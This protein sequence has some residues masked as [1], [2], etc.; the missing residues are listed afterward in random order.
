MKTDSNREYFMRHDLHMNTT[1]KEV[2]AQQIAATSIALFQGQKDNRN[3]KRNN[4]EN[5]TPMM[6]KIFGK[7][8]PKIRLT[9]TT[10]NETEKIINSI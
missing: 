2:C 7:S 6:T 1:G 5:S 10:T 8:F 4:M 3:I 9:N